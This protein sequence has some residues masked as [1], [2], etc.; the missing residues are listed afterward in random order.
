MRLEMSELD[1]KDRILQQACP[2]V[3]AP[4]YSPLPEIEGGYRYLMA[5]DGLWIEAKKPWG[6]FR[7]P[8]WLAPRPTAY[9]IVDAVFRL[10]DGPFPAGLIRECIEEATNDACN[11]K[12]W[13]GWIIWSESRGYEHRPLD[14]LD[15]SISHIRSDLRSALSEEEHLALDLHSH[16]FGMDRFSRTDDEDDAGGVY[17]S[18][19]ISFHEGM[20]PK[21]TTR[22]CIEGHYFYDLGD[23]Y[24]ALS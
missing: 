1:V 2:T 6:H 24:A 4:K 15:S 5:K 16:P 18:G 10:L 11:N 3:I 22:L 23:Y 14:V 17:F 9:G 19:V 8:L 12:E 20:K 21:L 13:A 7:L